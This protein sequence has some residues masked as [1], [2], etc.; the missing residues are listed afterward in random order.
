MPNREIQAVYKN[1][2]SILRL[3]IM[4]NFWWTKFSKNHRKQ[5]A[6]MY[7]EVLRRL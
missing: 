1:I 2:D 4:V 5:Y 6:T 3:V 7:E